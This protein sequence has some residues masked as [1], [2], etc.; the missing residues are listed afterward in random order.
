MSGLTDQTSIPDMDLILP[1]LTLVV[2]HKNATIT[3][4]SCV[5]EMI[6]RFEEIETFL[7]APYSYTPLKPIATTKGE[8]LSLP[9]SNFSTWLMNPKR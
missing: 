5:D 3:M 4:L 2:S 1:K 7:K 8:S 6:E 9:K